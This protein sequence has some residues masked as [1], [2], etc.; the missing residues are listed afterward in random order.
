MKIT[1]DTH[2]VMILIAG[3]IFLIL[4]PGV[5]ESAGSEPGLSKATVV[6]CADPNT[7]VSAYFKVIHDAPPDL[8]EQMRR[9]P[10]GA[11][12]HNHLPG[13]V[14]PQ[15]FI[16]LGIKEGN[17]YG[18]DRSDPTKSMIIPNAGTP[19]L[20]PQGSLPLSKMNAAD[21]QKLIESL[22]MYNFPYTD[23]QSGYNQFY[24]TF[25]RFGVK[26]PG[27]FS[28]NGIM[29]ANLLRNAE[30]DSV[31][32]VET[33]SYFQV[34]AIVSLAGKLRQKY[35]DNSHYTETGRYKEMLDFLFNSGLEDAV[36]AARKDIALYMERTK[37]IFKCG[38]P[39]EERACHIFYA[40]IAPVNR[41]VSTKGNPAGPDLPSMFTQTAFSFLLSLKDKNVAGVNL[42]GAEDWPVSMQTFRT[43][44]QFFSFFHSHPIFKDVSITLHAGEITPCFVGKGNPAL[45]EHRTESIHA[46]AK[47]LGHAVSTAHLDNQDAQEVVNLMKA[48]N[49]L[50]EVLFTVNAQILGVA[51][52]DHPFPFY[53]KNSVPVAF[54]TDD[55]GIS[56]AT[57]TDEW[58]YAFRQYDM[59]HSDL[60]RLAR[61]SLQY[62]FAPGAPLWQ[63]VSQAKIVDQC[64]YVT[65]GIPNPPDTCKA[66][67]AKSKKAKLQWDYEA[68]LNAYMKQFGKSF[69]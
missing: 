57:Y 55:E 56:Y 19:D 50:I 44:M 66:F 46:G 47:R 1:K 60:I 52:N 40:F 37:N 33:M 49:V 5:G 68:S 2:K 36:A 11:D 51:G 17:C 59:K 4:N 25:G 53:W 8:K 34:R 65:P 32:Y 9:F 18:V 58:V 45:K 3:L 15:T 13:S 39:F 14:M 42:V 10:K 6:R 54:S 20:C 31:S 7:A 22:S 26:P 62:S 41:N 28:I 29:L 63:D 64:R 48:K 21:Y 16:E 69:K 27:S 35:P 43:A 61:N 38:T 24:A 30:M 23:I 67:L 12:L